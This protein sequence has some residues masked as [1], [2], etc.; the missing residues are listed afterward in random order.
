MVDPFQSSKQVLP[1]KRVWTYV[2]ATLVI[3]AI[4]AFSGFGL[5]LS[6]LQKCKTHPECACHKI[7]KEVQPVQGPRYVVNG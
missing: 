3:V 1:G 5:A 6:A 2:I 7:L 4:I